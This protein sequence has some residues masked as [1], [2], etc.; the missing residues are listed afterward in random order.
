[1]KKSN[2]KAGTFFKAFI[3]LALIIS[4][5]ACD[6]ARMLALKNETGNTI[7]LQIEFGE[8]TNEFV[9]SLSES[10]ELEKV[11]LGTSESEKIRTFNLGLGS[12]YEAD[13]E[14]L[15]DCTQSINIKEVGKPMRKI[16]GE[17]LKKILPDVKKN[18]RENLVTITI[19]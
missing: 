11:I 8:C 15:I 2:L 6:P 16:E 7:E 5:C 17:E 18:T 13:L 3:G 12:W 10:K 9:Q 1:M 19:N 14:A 4:F